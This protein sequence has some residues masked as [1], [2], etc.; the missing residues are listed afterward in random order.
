[1]R[2]NKKKL[3]KVEFVKAILQ[4]SLIRKRGKDAGKP[5]GANEIH[6]FKPGK[7]GEPHTARKDR[8]EKRG[9]EDE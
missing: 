7:P 3:N 4:T 5:I 9:E 8:V 2:T 6:V 1:M